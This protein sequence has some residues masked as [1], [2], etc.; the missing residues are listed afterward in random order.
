MLLMDM[1][2]NAT[3]KV[4]VSG[5]PLP[6][7][8]EEMIVYGQGGS[9]LAPIVVTCTSVEMTN[10]FDDDDKPI[11]VIRFKA[12]KGKR[13]QLNAAFVG[14]NFISTCMYVYM[15]VG[16]CVCVCVR[17]CVRAC[18]RVPFCVLLHACWFDMY[19]ANSNCICCPMPTRARAHTHTYTPRFNRQVQ[20]QS[21]ERQPRARSPERRCGCGC[22]GAGARSR[23][24]GP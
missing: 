24:R 20:E 4:R 22:K 1:A 9:I 6:Q 2:T 14:G 23:R 10:Q 8:G 5:E 12:A 3:D 15:C 16:G 17:A 7:K 13:E 21:R 19:S 11:H 18:M